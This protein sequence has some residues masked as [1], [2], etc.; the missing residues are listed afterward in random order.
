MLANSVSNSGDALD[1]VSFVRSCNLMACWLL[2][3]TG[4]LA[5]LLGCR[6]QLANQGLREFMVQVRNLKLE[7]RIE[8]WHAQ[9][10]VKAIVKSSDPA[11][12]LSQ[13]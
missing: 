3:L 8:F 7:K 5:A 1:N 2:D 9:S 12:T 4:L 11:S 13:C 6:M 10:S